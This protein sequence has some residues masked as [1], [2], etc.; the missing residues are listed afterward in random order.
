MFQDGGIDA[1]MG[2]AVPGSSSVATTEVKKEENDDIGKMKQ[3]LSD[4]KS[5]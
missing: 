1:E 4:L 3:V 2:M 5:T